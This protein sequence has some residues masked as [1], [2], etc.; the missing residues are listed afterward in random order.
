MLF[1]EVIVKYRKKPGGNNP[2]NKY[3]VFTVYDVAQGETFTLKGPD[4]EKFSPV[5]I[6]VER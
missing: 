1:L 6:L 3:T 2:V 4:S 5:I